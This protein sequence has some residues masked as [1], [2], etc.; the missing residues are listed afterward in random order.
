M[1]P[2]ILLHF[3]CTFTENLQCK[4]AQ[5]LTSIELSLSASFSSNRHLCAALSSIPFFILS[6]HHYRLDDIV[7]VQWVISSN[8]KQL[9]MFYFYL[10]V[11]HSRIPY[12]NK[13][14]Q[15]T[16]FKSK[17]LV[18]AWIQAFA[19]YVADELVFPIWQQ[20]NLDVRIWC[21]GE[22]LCRKTLRTD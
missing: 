14:Y 4:L 12:N 13:Q 9:L 22:I 16:T 5:T 11:T 20:H 6:D 17:Q 19:L 3:Q 18:P 2:H 10:L 21:S 7:M 1:V 8:L 15:C